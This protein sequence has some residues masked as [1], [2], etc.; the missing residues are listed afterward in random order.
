LVEYC[1]RNNITDVN[2]Y[3]AEIKDNQ[4]L[5]PGLW[6]SCVALILNPHLFRVFDRMLQKFRH[7]AEEE[8]GDDEEEEVEDENHENEDETDENITADG[9]QKTKRTFVFEDNYERIMKKHVGDGGELD[10]VVTELK[11]YLEEDGGIMDMLRGKM[12]VL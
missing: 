8:G 1:R 3:L 2:E 10:A 9:N 11:K 4:A 7:K 6:L 12:M 5:L